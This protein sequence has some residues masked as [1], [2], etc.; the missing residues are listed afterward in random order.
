M[1]QSMPSQ[2]CPERHT[3]LV[4]ASLLSKIPD[5]NHAVIVSTGED[6]LVEHGRATHGGIVSICQLSSALHGANVKDGCGREG[7]EER[8][9]GR[10]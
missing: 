9:S 3:E 2:M 7:K 5:L 6:V 8:I 1:S 4:A 10:G